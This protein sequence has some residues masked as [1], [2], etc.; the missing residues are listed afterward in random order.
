[1]QANSYQTPGTTGGNREDL[2]NDLTIIEP[3]E[4][5]FFSLVPK[6]NNAKGTFH[7]VLADRLRVPRTSGSREGDAGAKG[8]NKAT[9]RQRFGAY[10]HRWHDS[11]SVTDVQQAIAKRGGTAAVDDEIAYA[12]MKCMREVKRDIEA[13]CCSAIET[14]GRTDDEMQL[15]GA[16]TWLA[17][18]NSPQVPSDFVPPAAQRVS[19]VTTLVETGA[20][21]L[22][23]ALKSLKGQYGV[24]KEFELIA[25]N[26]YIENL[27]MFTRTGDAVAANEKRF[28][29]M[30]TGGPVEIGLVVNVFRS[31]FGRVNIHASDFLLINSTTGV[32]QADACLILNMRLWELSFL[33]SLHSVE[34]ENDA[35]GESGFVKAIGGLFCKAPYG[36][37]FIK[38]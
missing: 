22:N 11:Y 5:P 23:A 10:L 12:E 27:D 3:E 26:S 16:F 36:N 37:A 19:S 25:G 4:T 8:G 14:Q 18:S 17:A 2:E 28:R 38:N 1:M 33:E 29:V 31:S 6:N 30:N 34:D 32:G 15:R 24:A 13:T 7:E 20:N 21:S 9:K 35:S